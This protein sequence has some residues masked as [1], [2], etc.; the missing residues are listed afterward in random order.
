MW[1]EWRARSHSQIGRRRIQR[2][3]SRNTETTIGKSSLQCP[4]LLNFLNFKTYDLQVWDFNPKWRTVSNDLTLLQFLCVSAR[5]RMHANQVRTFVLCRLT[6]QVPFFLRCHVFLQLI[7]ELLHDNSIIFR[8]DN[9][10]RFQLH[11]CEFWHQERVETW[12]LKVYGFAFGEP[13]IEKR[14]HAKAVRRILMNFDDF[15]SSIP[16]RISP[17][18]SLWQWACSLARRVRIEH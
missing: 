1:C 9:D 5:S 8:Q 15:I 12:D 11:S 3:Y 16:L 10:P 7:L 14:V 17:T 2:P 18:I 13:G 6:V 4:K